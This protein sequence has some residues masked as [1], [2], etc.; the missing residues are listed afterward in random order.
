M[1]QELKQL[2]QMGQ[3]PT[4]IQQ[5]EQRARVLGALNDFLTSHLTYPML[6]NIPICPEYNRYGRCPYT[7]YGVRQ[8]D[9]P[10]PETNFSPFVYYENI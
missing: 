7:I 6:Q 2:Q 1:Y 8:L 4:Q 10:L 5:A 9:S 3:T